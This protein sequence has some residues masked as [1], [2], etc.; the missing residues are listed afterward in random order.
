MILEMDYID[1]VKRILR[2]ISRIGSPA[3]YGE[4]FSFWRIC[5]RKGPM[6]VLVL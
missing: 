1:N 4:L 5:L 2:E 6:V 3:L